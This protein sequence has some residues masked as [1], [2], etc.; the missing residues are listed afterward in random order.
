MPTRD[1]IAK[2][3]SLFG[4]G[5]DDMSKEITITL[6]KNKTAVREG[7]LWII[8]A[9]YRWNDYLWDDVKYVE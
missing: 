9:D 7:G 4:E 5:N 6:N 8:G 3:N 1:D 2:F